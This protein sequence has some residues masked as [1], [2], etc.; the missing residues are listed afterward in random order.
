MLSLKF[1]RKGN[2]PQKTSTQRK[3]WLNNKH[4][5]AVLQEV[6][7]NADNRWG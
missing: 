6:S 5:N 2:Q 4:L 1:K 3:V 7:S